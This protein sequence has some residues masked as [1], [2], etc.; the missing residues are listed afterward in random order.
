MCGVVGVRRLPGLQPDGQVNEAL[1][2]VVVCR[3]LLVEGGGTTRRPRI[4]SETSSVS[5]LVLVVDIIE[6]INACLV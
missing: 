5:K 2:P 1:L 3:G 4:E 6:L